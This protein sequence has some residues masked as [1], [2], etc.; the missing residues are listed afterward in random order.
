MSKPLFWKNRL[1]RVIVPVP[2][3]QLTPPPPFGAVLKAKVLLTSDYHMYRA[4]RV[5]A[6]QGIQ[7]EPRP[8]PDV[9]KRGAGWRGRWPAFLD[10]L[11][12]SAKILYY[13]A[14]GWI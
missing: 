10:L 3:A 7:V 13:R 9:L 4:H 1:L 5:F 12:E 2:P 6:K 14:R 11:T 8:I